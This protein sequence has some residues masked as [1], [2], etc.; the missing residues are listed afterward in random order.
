MGAPEARPSTPERATGM[1]GH[2]RNVAESAG[3]RRG[4][5]QSC[6]KIRWPPIAAA[7][8]L[9]HIHAVATELSLAQKRRGRGGTQSLGDPIG[10]TSCC[11]S[12]ASALRHFAS[13]ASLRL[14][15][16]SFGLLLLGYGLFGPPFVT[17]GARGTKCAGLDP[18][19]GGA[20]QAEHPR[21]VLRQ[22]RSPTVGVLA[23]R[24]STGRAT[25]T[26]ELLS[27]NLSGSYIASTFAAGAVEVPAARTRA[28]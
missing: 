6:G 11:A 20:Q 25:S 1:Q 14:I 28:R 24:H 8:A 16:A 5:Q 18:A 3:A 9:I 4:V 7:D 21:F 22:A 27:P 17:S 12:L 15:K 10:R 2:G 19:M 13:S 26:C 23:R